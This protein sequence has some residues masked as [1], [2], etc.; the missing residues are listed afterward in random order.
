M[1]ISEKAMQLA[2]E[3]KQTQEYEDLKSAE[4]KLKLDPAAQ[5]LIN[6][7]QQKQEQLQTAQQSGEAVDQNVV[8]SLQN[9]QG[10]MQ[11]NETIKNLMEAQQQFDQVMKQVNE[12]VTQ[13]LSS[14]ES[15]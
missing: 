1:S 10:Q 6:D 14:E 5:D 11:E 9:L 7:F 13:A 4:A 8:Q 12:T 15:E 3:I 2:E